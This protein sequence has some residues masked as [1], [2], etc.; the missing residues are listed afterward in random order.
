MAVLVRAIGLDSAMTLLSA[1]GGT[2]IRL[3]KRPEHS[4]VLQELIGAEA[5]RK[6]VAAFPDDTYLRLPKRD[7]ITQQ[8]RYAQIKQ[9]RQ[10]GDSISALAL[11]HQLTIRQVQKILATPDGELPS[12][13]QKLSGM[14][15]DDTS[16][17]D[18]S[19]QRD[20]FARR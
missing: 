11:R 15:D 9:Q 12:W 17:T 2:V 3:P 20:L 13:R 8:L 14:R 18:E 6:L 7:K 10:A 16:P 19:V 1:R 4:C 5:T